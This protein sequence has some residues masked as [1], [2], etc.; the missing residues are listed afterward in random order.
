MK[1]IKVIGTGIEITCATAEEMYLM[2]FR[3]HPVHD[4]EVDSVLYPHSPTSGYTR[5]YFDKFF[6]EG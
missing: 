1:T 2:F 5:S 4:L 3:L 6:M